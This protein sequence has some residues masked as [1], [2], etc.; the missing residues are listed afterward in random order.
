MERPPLQSTLIMFALL[1]LSILSG[2]R[3]AFSQEAPYFPRPHGIYAIGQSTPSGIRE[4]PFVD[5]FVMRIDWALVEPQRGVYDFSAIDAVLRRLDTLG[6]HLTLDIFRMRTP[7]YILSTPGVLTH[8]LRLSRDSFYTAVP[9]DT[10]ALGRFELLH[11]ALAAHK[12]WSIRDG[13]AL[14]LSNHP[15]LRQ[16]DATPIGTNGI[17]D[18]NHSLTSHPTYSRGVFIEAVLGTAEIVRRYFPQTFCFVALFGMRDEIL[19]PPLTDAIRDSLLRRINTLPGRPMLG[20]FQE[21]LAC[22]G[23]NSQMS[24]PLYAARDS[25]FTM[26][27]MLQSWRKPFLDSTKTDVC[28]TDSTGPDVA[29][30]KALEVTHGMYFEIYTSDLDFPGYTSIFTQMH[31]SLARLNSSLTSIYP[32]GGDHARGTSEAMP[33]AIV[34][35]QN[36][37]NPLSAHTTVRYTVNAV[38]PG[39]ASGELRIIDMLGRCAAEYPLPA[40]STGTF[41]ISLDASALLPGVYVMR[42][43]AGT[44]MTTRRMLVAR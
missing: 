43:R 19:S 44:A 42:L 33:K 20:F 3:H 27:Q 7:N 37:P 36:F 6:Q 31:D 16:I 41:E 17:R 25:T 21:N 4:H 8:V 23:P 10:I 40:L 15:V 35:Q 29:M 24:N 22:N 11:E 2:G 14:P 32:P 28:R 34:L 1:L 5:G 12:V 13:A 9:W 38:L 30:L 39:V 26:Y 18:L